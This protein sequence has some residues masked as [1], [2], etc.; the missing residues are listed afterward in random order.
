MSWGDVHIYQAGVNDG[1]PVQ[2]P[3]L[4]ERPLVDQH[5]QVPVGDVLPLLS[6][7][8]ELEGLLGDVPPPGIAQ[9]DEDCL[10]EVLALNTLM[11]VDKRFYSVNHS[12]RHLVYL[13]EYEERCLTLGHI[14]PDPVLHPQLVDVRHL[15]VGEV[16]GGDE[17]VH[18]LAGHPLLVQGLSHKLCHEVLASS[19]PAVKTHYQGFLGLHLPEVSPDGPGHQGGDE[20]LPEHVLRQALLQ[21]G[22]IGPE[23]GRPAALPEPADHDLPAGPEGG[24]DHAAPHSQASTEGLQGV[25]AEGEEED[26]QECERGPHCSNWGCL[27]QHYCCFSHY[28]IAWIVHFSNGVTGLSKCLFFQSISLV[29]VNQANI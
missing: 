11:M 29:E 5:L 15:H 22:D 12:L 19:S 28:C 4:I 18:V 24:E 2:S 21:L 26:G 17:Q 27:Y 10:P 3:Q 20:V 1:T 8:P 7:G 16:Q 25:A 9:E 23:P 6:L 13:I 14:P